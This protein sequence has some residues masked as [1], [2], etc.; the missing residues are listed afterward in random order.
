MDCLSKEQ[1]LLLQQHLTYEVYEH[2][3]SMFDKDE[4][5]IPEDEEESYRYILDVLKKHKYFGEIYGWGD[6]ARYL[7][8]PANFRSS[9]FLHDIQKSP[10]IKTQKDLINYLSPLSDTPGIHN[11]SHVPRMRVKDSI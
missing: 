11:P 10:F 3:M 6:E 2:F 1:L 4:E 8:I 5:L 7:Y 9:R